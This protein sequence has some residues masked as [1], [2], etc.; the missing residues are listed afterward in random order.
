VPQIAPI[1]KSAPQ[2]L[3]IELL[4]GS[5]PFARQLGMIEIRVA[6][7]LCTKFADT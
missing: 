2:S 5:F 7:L 4:S 6:R 1:E 3:W